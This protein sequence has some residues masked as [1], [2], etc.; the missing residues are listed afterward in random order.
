MPRSHR[1]ATRLSRPPAQTLAWLFAAGTDPVAGITI[2]RNGLFPLGGIELSVI[3]SDGDY[4]VV[5]EFVSARSGKPVR[6]GTS[7]PLSRLDQLAVAWIEMR[8]GVE[9]ELEDRQATGRP[10]S[11]LWHHGSRHST[12]NLDTNGKV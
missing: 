9:I 5:L 2:G 10:Q 3:G 8:T 7:M 12:R 6:K 4:G 11:R 1:T